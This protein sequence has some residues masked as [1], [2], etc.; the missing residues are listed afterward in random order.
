MTEKSIHSDK[1]RDLETVEDVNNA[2]RYANIGISAEDAQFYDTFSPEERKKMM[3]KIDLRLVPVLALLYLAAHID[4]ANIGNAKIEGLTED[5]NMDGIKYNIAVSVFFIPYILLEVPSNVILK[6]FKRPSTYLGALVVSWG[7]VMTC[8]GVVKNFAGLMVTR[9]L[10]GITE[11]GFFPGAVYLITRW[12]AQR[13]VQTRLAFFYC[14][15]ALS[16]AFSGFLAFAIAKMNGVGG[17]PGWAWIFL[18][19]GIATV[20]I[21]CACFFIMPDTPQL[22]GRWL[23]E[24]EIRYLTIQTTIKEGG[25]SAMEK[26]DK[27]KWSYLWELLTDYKVYLQAWILFTASVCAY[28]LKFT[29]PSITKSMGFTS[30]EAQLMTIPPYVAGAIAA[31]TLSKLSDHFFW[32]M[33]FILLPMT[34]VLIGFCMLTPLAP[35]ITHQIPACYIAV[36]LICIGQY[37]TNPAGSAWISS[38]LAGDYKRAM[39]IAL[40]ICLGNTGG[41][42]GSY[43]FL[44]REK[45]G[46]PTGFGIGLSFAAVTLISTLVLEFSYWKINKK[47]DAI[48]EEEIRRQYSDEQLARM[49]DKSPLFR[50]KL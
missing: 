21:G 22:S 37:P 7:I 25:S 42:V 17:R 8:T 29:M 40:N 50:Y 43:M 44:E 12:Y 36:M 32:R 4:R 26:T 6:N 38:N 47:R 33:P 46:Y 30:S 19:E 11:A 28:G 16:G 34:S 2:N 3:W 9:V 48:D 31:V 49:G 41:I 27:F 13:E 14:A 1:D 39:G 35:D 10:L 24:K 20:L 5:L 15:S 45:P 23:S 18:L